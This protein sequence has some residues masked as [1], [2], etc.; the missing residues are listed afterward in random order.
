MTKLSEVNSW[1]YKIKLFLTENPVYS[2]IILVVMFLLLAVS[3]GSNSK[4]SFKYE[5][6]NIKNRQ[7]RLMY[8][9]RMNQHKYSH[10]ELMDIERELNRLAARRKELE[11]NLR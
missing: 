11:H 2:I 3:I 6:E 9:Y 8:E 4:S 7:N 10:I 1:K 5:L